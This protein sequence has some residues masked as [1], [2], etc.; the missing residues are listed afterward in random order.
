MQPSRIFAFIA[1][2]VTTLAARSAVAQEAVVPD[3][4]EAWRDWVLHGEEHR[5]CPI[6][7]GRP[8]GDASSYVCAWPGRLDVDVAAGRAEFALDW[9]VYT[10]TSVPLPG[11]DLHWPIDVTVDGASLPVVDREGRP[12]LQL[13][14]GRHRVAGAL[15]W[16]TRP[17]SIEVP[18]EIGLVGLRLDGAAVANPELEGSTLWLGLRPD[19]VVEEDR[20]DVV[21]YRRLDDTL[22]MVADTRIELDVAGQSRELM[23]EGAL[24]DGFVGESLDSDLPAQLDPTGIL[25]VQVRPGRWE[26]MLTAHA[27]AA[28]DSISVADA[29]APWP[30]DEVWSFTPEPRFRVAALEGA[31]AVDAAQSGVPP[32]WASLPSYAVAAGQTVSIV[33]RSRNDAAEPNRLGLRRDL[34]LDFD[35]GG[36]TARDFVTGEMH[37]GWRLDMAQPYTMTMASIDGENLLITEGSDPGTQGVEL[38]ATSV[39]LTST[40]RLTR[41]GALPVTGYAESFD[42]AGTTLHVPPGHRLLGAPGASI[43]VGAWYDAWRLLDIFLVLVIV[44]AC[45]RMFGPAAG[46][47]ALAA[48][49][50]S[51]HEPAAPRWTWL[52]VLVAIALARVAP[53]GRLKTFARR[54]RW[55]SVAALV[56][57]LVPFAAGQLRTVVFPQLER[58]G[59]QRGLASSAAAGFVSANL[60]AAAPP[61]AR[62]RIAALRATEPP[63]PSEAGALEELVVGG[64]RIGRTVS[65]Y[66]PGALVQTGPGLPDWAWNRYQLRFDGPVDEGQTFRLILLGPWMVALWRVASVALAVALLA[67][68]ALPRFRLPGAGA[69]ARRAG[70]AGGAAAGVVLA[71]AAVWSAP[72]SAQTASEFP[73]PALLDEL[74]RRLT[75]PARCRPRCAELTEARVAIEGTDLSIDLEFAVE[76]SSAVP[77]P[78]VPRVW[79]PDA[80]RVDGLDVG[81]A[82]RDPAETSWLRL[83]EGVHRVLLSGAMPATGSLTLPFPL[84]PRR[85]AVDAPGWD[86]AGVTDGRLPSGALELNRQAQEGDTD[87]VLSGSVFPPYVRVTRNVVFDLDWSVETRVERVAPA[88]G[89]FTLGIALLPDEAVITPGIDANAGRATAAFVAGQRVVEWESRLPTANSLTLTAADDEP[90]SETWR[91][92]VGQIWHAEFAGLPATPP[93]LADL[94]FYTPE[95]YPRPGESL[96]VNLNRPASASGDTIAIDSVE[97]ERDVGARVSQSTLHFAYRSTR[98]MEHAITLPAGSELESVEID[99]STIPLRLDGGRLGIPITPGRHDVE[100]A[101]RTGEGV[102]ARVGLPVVD[103][104]GGASNILSTLDLPADRWILLTLGPTLGPAVLYWPELLVFTLAALVLGRIPWSPFKT[105]EWLFLGFGLSTFAWPVLFLFVVWAFVLSWRGRTEIRLS[106]RWFNTAQVGFAILTVAAL[107]ALIGAIPVGLLGQADMQIVSP[108]RPGTLSWFMDRTAAPT[109]DVT[110]VSVS[111]WFYRAAMLAWSLWLSFAL[112]RWLRWAWRAFSHGGYWRGRVEN[113]A[114]AG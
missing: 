6:L 89:A 2:A 56:V 93:E 70:R 82:L 37:R 35:G 101:W 40:A 36:F 85:I 65:R 54:Y 63:R 57:L 21:V 86:V 34:W 39:D 3:A 12:A 10:E 60:P 28:P 98:G 97:Y 43:A 112:L 51:Y 48:L 58:P 13:S 81:F 19:A 14:A 11:G 100:I 72:G 71:V 55:V 106:R 73:P 45:W 23:L 99:G 113:A 8:S 110:V 24:L 22:P 76:A 41:G 38:R 80:I 33:E 46:V 42:G 49:L 88:D 64:A 61:G 32:D 29:E 1:I 7:N 30:A 79:R 16:Q 95:Y 31:P 44:T 18:R 102:A 84:P 67:A 74:K 53:E 94:S 4:L 52:N 5:A 59:L 87:E 27:S 83:E 50:L 20:L 47:L 103:L 91:F 68:L 92:T 90:W 105:H 109:P 9:T 75:E 104:G 108:V 15:V 77:I 62:E 17:A 111:F 25:R 114:A 69:F 96:T 26:L 78:T 107:G 66:V